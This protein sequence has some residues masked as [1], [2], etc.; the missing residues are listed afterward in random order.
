MPRE[1]SLGASLLAELRTVFCERNAM[2]SKAILAAIHE[3]PETPWSELRGKPLDE[4]GL[5][6]RLGQYSVK[7]K[8]LGIEEST[9]RGYERADLEEQWARY[10]LPSANIS[11][12]SKTSETSEEN[13]DGNVADDVVEAPRSATRKPY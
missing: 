3:F 13:K 6:N 2:A 5:S 1:P 7:P 4:R 11:K 9:P 10:L 12:T 8:T